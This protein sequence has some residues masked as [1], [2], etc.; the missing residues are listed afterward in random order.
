MNGPTGS[1]LRRIGDAITA[2]STRTAIWTS[3]DRGGHGFGKGVAGA[4]ARLGIGR[5]RDGKGIRQRVAI[6]AGQGAA[7][8]RSR[9]AGPV[10][11]RPNSHS[12]AMAASEN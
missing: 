7:L 1:S 8:R 10:M 2:S 12:K 4:E 11:R 5:E 3:I 9:S 6:D